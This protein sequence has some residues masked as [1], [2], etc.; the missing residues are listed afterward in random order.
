MFRVSLVV[1]IVTFPEGYIL[2][3]WTRNAK[4]NILS[5]DHCGVL[6]TNCH[7]AVTWRCNDLCRDAIR[8]AEEGATSPMIYK[9]AKGALQ[10]AFSEVFAAKKGSSFNGTR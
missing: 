1:G 2:R 3:R 9:V 7:K 10:K 8:F 6:Q 4:S 5:Y